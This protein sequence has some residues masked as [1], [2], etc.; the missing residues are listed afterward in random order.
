MPRKTKIIFIVVFILVGGLAFWGYS[1]FTKGNAPTTNTTTDTG[2]KP[3][4]G[5]S[6]TPQ[7]QG[8]ENTTSNLTDTEV[9]ITPTGTEQTS[10]Q[11]SRFTQITTFAVAG[12]TFFEDTRPLPAGNTPTVVPT[13]TQTV[14][15]KTGVKTKTVAKTPEPKFEVVPSIRY[16]ERASGHINQMYLDTK[17][18][19]EISNSTIPSVY[20]ALFDDKASSV[21]Y[22]YLSEDG[23]TITSFLATLGGAKGEFLPQN[24]TDVSLSPDRAKFFYITKTFSGSVG[25]IRSFKDTKKVQVF[26]SSLSEWLSQWVSD[27]KVYLT[28][29]AAASI[30]GDLFSVNTTTGVMTKVLGDI[31]GLTTLA[32]KDGSTILYSISTPS[33]PKLQLF[34]VKT[35]TTNDLSVYGLPEKCV[36]SETIIYC[37]VPNSIDSNQYPD[38]WYQGRVSFDDRFIKIN[39]LNNQTSAL[40][41]GVS[42][43]PIDGTHLFL[44]KAGDTLFFI[45]K[46][47]STLWSLSLN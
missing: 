8:G 12:A 26:S 30:P 2:Y 5:T 35:H 9:A 1:Y 6:N 3:F 34:D 21:I 10:N 24:I 42:D 22:R 11:P 47:D 40:A 37:A 15:A 32:N 45:N 13:T 27:Q 18:K 16:V 44:T 19:G 41:G 36:W 43:T 17:A 31:P 7:T 14:P 25:T 28:T 46:K 38:T 20:E 4:L 29:K 23:K 39:T 33:G